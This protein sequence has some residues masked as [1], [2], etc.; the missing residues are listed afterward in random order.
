VCPNSYSSAR[1]ATRTRLHHWAPW[2]CMCGFQTNRGSDYGGFV[3]TCTILALP[4][5]LFLVAQ[6]RIVSGLTAGAVEG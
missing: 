2:V 6:R 3:T 4:V 5:V 1:R